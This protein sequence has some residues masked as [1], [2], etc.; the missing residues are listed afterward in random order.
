[1]RKIRTN[2]FY[3]VTNYK[4]F[5]SIRSYPLIFMISFYPNRTNTYRSSTKNNLYPY[6]FHLKTIVHSQLITNQS[7]TSIINH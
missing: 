6:S 5:C 3:F 4:W 7:F 2:H 1:M